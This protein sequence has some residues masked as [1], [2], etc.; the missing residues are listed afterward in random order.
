MRDSVLA[1]AKE[2][3]SKAGIKAIRLAIE[4]GDP[5]QAIVRFAEVKKADFIVMGSRGLSDLGGLVY[6]SV[7]H[8]VGHLAPCTC[9]T[10][11]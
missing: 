7:S 6:G 1:P 9:V 4:S 11:H 3:L 8:K 2:R 5:A 10:V